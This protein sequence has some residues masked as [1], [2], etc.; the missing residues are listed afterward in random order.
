MIRF[1]D[2]DV[3][4]YKGKNYFLVGKQITNCNG[5]V[6]EQSVKMQILTRMIIK[7][8]HHDDDHRNFTGITS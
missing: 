8:H 1:E 5:I 7:L 2:Y 6:T 4:S 3:V